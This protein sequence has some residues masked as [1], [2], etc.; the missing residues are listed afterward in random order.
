MSALTLPRRAL[1]VVIDGAGP[2]GPARGVAVSRCLADSLG[3]ERVRAFAM[4]DGDVDVGRDLPD[5]VLMT[6]RSSA[7]STG[8]SADTAGLRAGLEDA[9]AVAMACDT[10]TSQ[11]LAGMSSDAALTTA[12]GPR[13]AVGRP[14]RE[15]MAEAIGLPTP[16]R[17]SSAASLSMLYEFAVRHDWR[18]ALKSVNGRSVAINR[19]ADLSRALESAAGRRSASLDSTPHGTT[20]V[21]AL[22]AHRGTVVGCAQTTASA[23]D[24]RLVTLSAVEE[25]LAERLCRALPQPGCSGGLWLRLVTEQSGRTWVVDAE[26]GFPCWTWEAAGLGCNLPVALARSAQSRSGAGRPPAHRPVTAAQAVL[27]RCPCGR[28]DP[29]READAAAENYE[30][31]RLRAIDT[32][33]VSPE[34]LDEGTRALQRGSIPTP[35]RILLH[36]ASRRRFELVAGSLRSASGR[37]ALKISAAYSVKTNPAPELIAL[38]MR[39]GMFL[40]VVSPAELEHVRRQGVPAQ[41]IVHNGPLV[42]S[43][44]RELPLRAVFADSIEGLALIA[45]QQFAASTIGLRVAALAADGSRMSRFGIDLHD[46]AALASAA[47]LLSGSTA[48]QR[49]GLSFH[50]QSRRVGKPLW[51][52]NL[53]RLADIA[54]RLQEACGRAVTTI[55]VGGGFAPSELSEML[56]TSLSDFADCVARSAPNLSEFIIEPGSALAEDAMALLVTVLERRDAGRDT[57]VV[58]DGSIAELRDAAEYP[59]RV[60]ALGPSSGFCLRR[61]EHR[62]VG[63]LPAELD[64]L[65]TGIDIPDT[66][67]VGDRL[68]ILDCGGYDHSM[69]FAFADGE[70]RNYA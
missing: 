36:G 66:V 65:V 27:P 31:G 17:V 69:G 22:V 45:R 24:D 61:G 10:A 2:A 7:R 52:A 60:L 4:R 53:A 37:G 54:G 9:G 26:A 58:V 3:W 11:W 32:P 15:T 68:A 44:A 48:H 59:H 55:D 5:G 39:H 8:A 67:G 42:P 12:T 63:R 16:P 70:S 25:P 51:Y 49:L 64:V 34:L 56:E 62:I 20:R 19:F 1:V 18:V 41:R 21:I 46:D 35:A 6:A 29:G 43:H 33:S 23:S 38:A 28:D 40:E 57:T 14:F 13:E 50:L 47:R 30:S